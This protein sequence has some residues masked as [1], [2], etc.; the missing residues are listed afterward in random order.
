MWNTKFFT[1]TPNFKVFKTLLQVLK[2]SIVG[3]TDSAVPCAMLMDLAFALKPMLAHRNQVLSQ[4]SL[5]E[6]F[7]NLHKIYKNKVFLSWL[8]LALHDSCCDMCRFSFRKWRCN[9]YFSTAKRRSKPGVAMTTRTGRDIWRRE[10]SRK[11]MKFTE[12]FTL[13][14]SHAW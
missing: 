12:K 4:S 6:D 5:T 3:A 2:F 8:W 14:I 1:K 9:W 10:W 13:T 11:Q 7:S